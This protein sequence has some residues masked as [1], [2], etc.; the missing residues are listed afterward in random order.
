MAGAGASRASSGEVQMTDA[1]KLETLVERWQ[2]ALSGWA[3]PPHLTSEGVGRRPM[4][5]VFSRRADHQLATP[6]PLISR[7]L[8]AL[9]E[10]GT[11][12]DV[13]AGA[14]A[15]SLPLAARTG[16]LIAVDAD[17]SMLDELAQRASSLGLVAEVVE[18][19]W[20]DV[21][22]AV[23]PVDVVVCGHVLYNVMDLPGFVAALTDHA[24]HRVVYEFT[25]RHPL[26]HLS[27]LWRHFHGIDRPDR[28]TA[29][30]A[31]EI[32]EALGLGIHVERSTPAGFS[33]PF[34]ELVEFT[35]AALFVPPQRADE[36]AD[37]LRGLG[38]DPARA[39]S[40]LGFEGQVTVW[41]PGAA[42]VAPTT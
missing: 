18:G 9:P 42:H 24:R 20:P 15:A 32:L 31:I 7:A 22:A 30:D 34:A 4:V 29:D 36:V 38:V 14:G 37:G 41:W 25:Q 40:P 17:A 1:S 39:T 11:V 2:E 5:S 23:P 35:R 33:Q 27:P 3:V 16:R 10:G 21:A 6:G 8:E 13:G 12:L 19:R 26:A 28:P